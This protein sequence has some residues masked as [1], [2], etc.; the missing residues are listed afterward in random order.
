MN[1]NVT[2]TAAEPI[3]P[4]AEPRGTSRLRKRRSFWKRR[5]VLFAAAV[6]VAA[7]AGAAFWMSSQG[8]K[9]AVPPATAAVTRGNVQETV[10]ATGT[11]QANALVSVGAQVSG[12]IK[13]LGVKLGDTVKAGQVIA[14]IDSLT[15][16]N[17][18][19]AAKAALAI[20]QAQKAG[21]QV[22][23]DKADKAADRAVT[24]TASKQMSQ[25]DYDTAIAARDSAKA[26]LQAIDAQI[27]Q[28]N[29]N[30]DSATLDLSRTTISAPIDG[31]VVAIL[32]DQGQTV[33]A[34]QTAPTIVK[35]ADLDSMVIKAKISEADVTRVQPG[36]KVTFTVLGDSTPI[37]AMLTSI[38][39]APTSIESDAVST[40]TAIYYNGVF[41]VPNPNHKLR[42]SMTA[43]V[44]I[45]LGEAR[46]VLTIPASALKGAG[47]ATVARVYDA[48]TGTSQ[49]RP[50]KVGLNNKV[51]AEIVSGLA[52]GDRVVTGTGVAATPGERPAGAGGFGAGFGAPIPRG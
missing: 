1:A 45:T 11:L 35:I 26:Q 51:T 28:A 25:A 48:A 3:G 34:T 42:I 24:L 23:F 17:K 32:V 36:Q 29:L 5:S 20:V 16:E 9:T 12:T 19:K 2:L 49:P 6:I 15:Q 43:N 38:E 39:P 46:N 14:E 10:L 47:N 13:T 7:G 21:Q 8:T 44:T 50:V 22:A 40:D 33:S 37:Q 30:V 18:V 27:Q 4:M 31:T 52:E 41:T